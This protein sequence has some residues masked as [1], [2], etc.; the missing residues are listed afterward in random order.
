MSDPKKPTEHPMA[1][2]YVAMTGASAGHDESPPGPPV[3]GIVDVGHEPDSFKVKSILYVPLAVAITMLLAYFVV[4]GLFNYMRGLTESNDGNANP[5]AKAISSLTI[6]Q[7]FDRISSMDDKA[8]VKQPRLEWL[9]KSD[10]KRNG[11][12]DPPYVRSVLPS[13]KGNSPEY[14]P[15][16]L[17]PHNY[18]D[19]ITKQKVLADYAWVNKDKGVAR[20]PVNVAMKL[21]LAKGLPVQ[22]NPSAPTVGT[23]LKPKLSNGGNE[24]PAKAA[25]DPK[26]VKHDDHDDHDHGKKDEKKNEKKDH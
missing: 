14:R 24:L 16:D 13:D 5:Q 6:D 20:I 17:L 12:T 7:R 26:A 23:A 1:D 15:E 18:I 4:T 2:L 3:G 11:E 9:R 10:S 25:S 21:V 8:A 19:P 22:A